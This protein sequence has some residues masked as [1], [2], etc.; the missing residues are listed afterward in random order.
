MKFKFKT[1]AKAKWSLPRREEMREALYFG[2]E[3]MGIAPLLEAEYANLKLVLGGNEDVGGYCIVGKKYYIVNISRELSD[4][5][6]ELEA[7]FHELQHVK[8]FLEGR[9]F[10]VDFSGDEFT[11]M[12]DGKV[13]TIDS[14]KEFSE[15]NESYWNAPWEVE[16]R[17]VGEQIFKE[18]ENR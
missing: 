2:V 3:R 7:L 11:S 1:K 14:S 10:D 13:Y 12:F 16:A 8:Q 4:S 9:L 6:Y 18:W 5:D 17:E 15:A